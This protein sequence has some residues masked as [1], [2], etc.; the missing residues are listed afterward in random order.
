MTTKACNQ[1]L[2]Q[3]E[4]VQ[5]PLHIGATVFTQQ[6]G[7]FGLLRAPPF[8]DI[9]AKPP[10]TTKAW[11]VTTQVSTKQ[12]LSAVCVHVCGGGQSNAGEERRE[13][14]GYNAGKHMTTEQKRVNKRGGNMVIIYKKETLGK[15]SKHGLRSWH[16]MVHHGQ[17]KRSENGHFPDARFLR[18]TDVFRHGVLFQTPHKALFYRMSYSKGPNHALERSKP[19]KHPACLG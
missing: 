11:P 10:P 2:I 18:F 19:T 5:Q 17:K 7:E 4:L 9:P 13:K 15:L 6:L 16:D 1:R 3:I 8:R 14:G 12:V